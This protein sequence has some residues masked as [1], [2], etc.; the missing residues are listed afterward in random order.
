MSA[1]A[2]GPAQAPQPCSR[3]RKSRASGLGP[4]AAGGT[5]PRPPAGGSYIQKSVGHDKEGSMRMS[6]KLTAAALAMWGLVGCASE[7]ESTDRRIRQ[8]SDDDGDGLMTERQPEDGSQLMWPD[9]GDCP[10]L[11][12]RETH[13][14]VYD[15]D[16]NVV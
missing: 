11:E 10:L 12:W 6:A 4:P 15:A 3:S 7:R 13:T 5:S 14:V 9:P 1:V 8:L 16:G 2:I